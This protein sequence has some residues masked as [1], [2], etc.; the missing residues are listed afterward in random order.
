VLGTTTAALFG[1]V[2][3]SRLLLI[4][5]YSAWLLG[6]AQVM[7]YYYQFPES[8]VDPYSHPALARTLM[9][10]ALFW[11]L[12]KGTSRLPSRFRNPWT[13]GGLRLAYLGLLTLLAAQMHLDIA[14]E[15]ESTVQGIDREGSHR[16]AQL[17]GFEIF[18]LPM[19]LYRLIP[20]D[21]ETG[22]TLKRLF[23]KAFIAGVVVSFVGYL[24]RA[25]LGN[26]VALGPWGNLAGLALNLG[27]IY[28][29]AQVIIRQKAVQGSSELLIVGAAASFG[30][31]AGYVVG[32][33]RLLGEPLGYVV[34][35]PYLLDISVYLTSFM[36]NPPYADILVLKIFAP[37]AIGLAAVL[38]RS[39]PDGPKAWHDHLRPFAVLVLA[40]CYAF[41][42]YRD[43]S[44]SPILPLGGLFP[45]YF[46]LGALVI[47]VWLYRRVWDPDVQSQR[48]QLPTR[49]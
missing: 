24:L 44:N 38:S 36:P 20:G 2:Q 42:A 19:I 18:L 32:L 15:A 29:V 37:A 45:A 41:P 27:M 12:L 6:L 26:P 7:G 28:A 25:N 39:G 34:G 23:R 8:F 46:G 22:V 30:Y 9:F 5:F 1:I 40:L 17:S 13:A 47:A 49:A 43:I 10:I 11:E 33:P 21:T 48:G 3:P 31:V 14:A 4:V 16:A 35:W